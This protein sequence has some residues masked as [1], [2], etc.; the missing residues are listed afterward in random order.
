MG[1]ADIATELGINAAWQTLR[2]NV[3][4]SGET[5]WEDG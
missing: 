4:G 1:N 3:R 2:D 5:R